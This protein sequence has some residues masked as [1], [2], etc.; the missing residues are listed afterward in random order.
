L[1][2]EGDSQRH[3]SSNDPFFDSLE[4][5]VI[6]GD[7]FYHTTNGGTN[8]TEVSVPAGTWS[9]GARFF[10]RWHGV[11]VGEAGN[12][13]RTILTAA[14]PGKRSSRRVPD[15]SCG[16]LNIPGRTPLSS[17]GDNGVISRSIDGGATWNSIQS[18]GTVTH[19]FDAI[20]GR[21]HHL[22]ELIAFA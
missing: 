6:G 12:I 19:D 4:G 20:D 11:A 21:H 22:L 13:L 3:E 2:A 5:W 17:P 14:R 16:P 15:S 18:G 9:Y 7:S 10:D 1:D 8:W